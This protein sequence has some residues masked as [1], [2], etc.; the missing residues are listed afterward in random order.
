RLTFEKG[1][2][3]LL[4][5]FAA[6]R[7]PARLLIVG[8]GPMRGELE[9]RARWLGIEGR[10]LFAGLQ[11]PPNDWLAAMDVFV[12]PSTYEG[13][14]M[15]ALEAMA[16]ARPVIVARVG[17]LAELVEDGRTG[18]VIPPRDPRA[19]AEAIERLLR[20][21]DLRLR[22]G[23]AARE[24]ARERTDARMIEAYFRLY[25][26]GAPSQEE[27]RCGEHPT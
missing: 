11:A 10:V 3:D 14:G 23:A 21:I 24:A 15:A 26:Q 27:P 25:G 9:A 19:L 17:G 5:G 6:L 13:F 16:A 7:A 18:I 1:L 20:D 12:L 22:L 8:E 4:D 2:E